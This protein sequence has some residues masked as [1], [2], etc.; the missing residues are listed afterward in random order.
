M[1]ATTASALLY[2]SASTKLPRG[3]RER[4]SVAKSRTMLSTGCACAL[5]VWGFGGR[6]EAA[7][8]FGNAGNVPASH[9]RRNS[10]IV[11]SSQIIRRMVRQVL[12]RKT[13]ACWPADSCTFCPFSDVRRLS[14]TRG[15]ARKARQHRER[16]ARKALIHRKER[17]WPTA[18]AG[19]W[20]FGA[21]EET[22]LLGSSDFRQA[23]KKENAKW[24][25]C[26]QI[27]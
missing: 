6:A 17:D 26:S 20:G 3:G 9:F 4:T 8:E 21:W 23:W 1:V 16:K 19:L 5:R 7:P 10:I 14:T 2:R 12:A 18:T 13:A 11:E 15:S 25:A 22:A 27:Q 24:S